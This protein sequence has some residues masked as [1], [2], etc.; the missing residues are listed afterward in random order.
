L[1]R[2]HEQVR[3]AAR[4]RGTTTKSAATALDPVLTLQR[5]AGNRAVAQVLA[6]QAAAAT[7]EQQLREEIAAA[8]NVAPDDPRV[9][10][11]LFGDLEVA[12]A[13]KAARARDEAAK[14]AATRT[15][16]SQ[17]EVREDPY[18]GLTL[19]QRE[20]TIHEDAVKKELA[21][22]GITDEMLLKGYRKETRVRFGTSE[23]V[24]VDEWIPEGR[25]GRF[26]HTYEFQRAGTTTRVKTTTDYAKGGERTIVRTTISGGKETTVTTL[27]PGSGKLAER[28]ALEKTSTRWV[29]NPDGSVTV[30]TLD[31][32]GRPIPGRSW[33]PDV[34]KSR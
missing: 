24:L 2:I 13:L 23:G 5:S 31:K 9:D 11:A 27:E 3:P 16:P 32:Y 18:K 1:R 10:L 21:N 34:L 15:E 17:P 33:K 20:R 29:T 25:S 14:A 6:R 19:E 12:R 7:N 28:A 26:V 4:Q 8:M 30:E 22:Q